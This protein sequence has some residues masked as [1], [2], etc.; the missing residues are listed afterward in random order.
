MSRYID[1]GFAVEPIVDHSND[2]DRAWMEYRDS[3]E[4][5]T[6]AEMDKA[7]DVLA[8]AG[9]VFESAVKA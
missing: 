8:T 4:Y 9:L 6:P 1:Y 7:N 5:K 3:P 2:E